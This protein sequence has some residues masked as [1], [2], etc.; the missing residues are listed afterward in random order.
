MENNKENKNKTHQRINRWT[1]LGSIIL[2]YLIMLIILCVFALPGIVMFNNHQ[3]DTSV[4]LSA[5]FI[6]FGVAIVLSKDSIMGQS[7]AKRILHFQIVRSKTNK[8]ANSFRCIIRNI[9][10][11]IWPIEILV[12]IFSPSR[13][14]GDIVAG[15]KLI[16]G[17]DSILKEHPNYKQIVMS[18]FVTY[19]SLVLFLV[20]PMVIYMKT[21]APRLTSLDNYEISTPYYID[22]IKKIDV[23]G[24]IIQR[25]DHS[26]ERL[27]T[28]KISGNKIGQVKIGMNILLKIDTAENR[29]FNAT[30]EYISPK[31]I[32]ENDDEFFVVKARIELE[33]NE[34]LR[35]GNM[36]KGQIVITKRENVLAVNINALIREQHDSNYVEVEKTPQQFELV[37]VTTG[38]T[39]GINVEIVSGLSASDKIKVL[40]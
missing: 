25:N 4:I 2:D 20:I 37:P 40:K 7:I 9:F 15:T 31:G 34:I 24:M 26:N 1:R 38:L 29:I 13:R 39:D 35:T 18:F 36:A 27:F 17:E 6:Y 21:D 11:I 19:F 8:I 22:I 33:G 3:N 14:I 5:V 10:V 30:I 28:L 23:E 16:Y 12:T 32:V